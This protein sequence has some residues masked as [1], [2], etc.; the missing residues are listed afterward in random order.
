MSSKII[1]KLLK[2]SPTVSVKDTVK[3]VAV[4]CTQQGI[5][6]LLPARGDSSRRA[7][8]A[9]VP[10]EGQTVCATGVCSAKQTSETHQCDECG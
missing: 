10:F 8:A 7:R 3:L 2:V 9:L 4:G 6:L 1:L 5:V